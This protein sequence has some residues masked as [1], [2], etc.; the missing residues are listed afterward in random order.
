[1][2]DL[3]DGPEG[4]E[5]RVA[6]LEEIARA[7]RETL[8]DIR[9]ELRGIRMEL[10]S[11]RTDVADLRTE[12]HANFTDLRAEVAY[13][14]GRIEQLPSTWQM[15]TGILAGQIALGILFVA[16]IWFAGKG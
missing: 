10:V 2:A 11:I 9:P 5:P 12:M 6:V 3:V 14:K 1:M 13:L 4:L 15:I 16:A 7:T 8:V